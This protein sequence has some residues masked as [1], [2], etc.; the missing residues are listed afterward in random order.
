MKS[1]FYCVFTKNTVYSPEKCRYNQRQN[2]K[3]KI[4]KSPA[5]D[6]LYTSNT[7]PKIPSNVPIINRG[8]LIRKR[9][10]E[11]N[12][13]EKIATIGISIFCK[14]CPKLAVE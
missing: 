5:A 7:E 11:K 9:S 13:K 2:S 4:R 3:V 12:R 8:C 6:G 1:L 14:I 10:S